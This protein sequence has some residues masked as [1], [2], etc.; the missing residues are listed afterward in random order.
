[1]ASSISVLT[2]AVHASTQPAISGIA[3]T[4]THTH[5]HTRMDYFGLSFSQQPAFSRSISVSLSVDP[6]PSGVVERVLISDPIAA[7]WIV[8]WQRG[9]AI[10]SMGVLS[11]WAKC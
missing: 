1:M 4:H 10:K 2:L 5:A 11:V 7:L 6:S 3:H 9:A 8:M